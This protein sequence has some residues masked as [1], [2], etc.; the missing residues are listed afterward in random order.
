MTAVES[1]LAI[2]VAVLV[3]LTVL[4]I[5]R[6]PS[7]W[8]RIP[9]FPRLQWF[10]LSAV[11]LLLS[12]LVPD[13]DRVM[14]VGCAAVSLA[15]LLYQGWWIFPFTPLK[16]PEVKQGGAPGAERISIVVANVLMSNRDAESL[17][18][19]VRKLRPDLLLTLESDDWWESQLDPLVPDYPH[20]IKCP[21]DDTYGIHLYSRLPLEDAQVEY[22]VE[23]TVPSVHVGVR[24]RGGELVRAHFLHPAPP[25][26]MHKADSVERDAELI[27]LARTIKDCEEPL[28]VAGD[29]NDVAWSGTTRLFR[30]ISGLLDPRVGR[31]MFNTFHAEYR[32]MRWPLDHLFHSAHFRVS[33]I[34]RLE[35]FGSDHFPLYTELEYVPGSVQEQ[36][37]PEP[38]ERDIEEARNL[39]ER[40][41]PNQSTAH[42]PGVEN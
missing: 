2:A 27:V 15:C 41:S 7:W 4:P 36:A 40:A 19:Q 35:P 28:I 31:G 17:L 21:Q 25:V 14:A 12:L 34:A 1:L 20:F 32:F 22:L 9:E 8:V 26:P 38:G 24:M 29:L 3:A 33:R 42:R 6:S 37:P 13:I 5:S 39:K 11:L 23:D 16:S 18:S 10:A 30:R